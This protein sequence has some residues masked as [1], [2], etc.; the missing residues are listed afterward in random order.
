M[1]RFRGIAEQCSSPVSLVFHT[2]VNS[3]IDLK[4]EIIINILL[5]YRPH[6]GKEYHDSLAR[7]YK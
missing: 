4:N 5:Y 2:I 3:E 7:S 6:K 1:V